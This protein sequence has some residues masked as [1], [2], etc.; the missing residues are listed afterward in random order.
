METQ[1]ED[2]LL[3]CIIY[4]AKWK[5]SLFFYK[6]STFA[7]ELTAFI[8]FSI[9]FIYS[10]WKKMFDLL[11]SIYFF[12]KYVSAKNKKNYINFILS[13]LF[14]YKLLEITNLFKY[15]KSFALFKVI[16][17]DHVTWLRIIVLL[18]CF[19]RDNVSIYVLFTSD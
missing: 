8:I 15:K 19:R 16:I 3:I 7:L 10:T 18:S 1:Q 5:P 9:D 11:K 2:K 14:P 17:F 13:S 6:Y 4:I 12:Y